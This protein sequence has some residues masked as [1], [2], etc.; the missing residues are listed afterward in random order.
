MT[1]VE[2]VTLEASNNGGAFATFDTSGI[3]S[4]ERITLSADSDDAAYS[5][6]NL[7]DGAEVRFLAEATSTAVTVDTAGTSVTLMAAGDTATT[8]TISDAVTVNVK[9]NTAATNDFAALVLDDDV[10]T[11]LTLTGSTTDGADLLTGN[12]TGSNLL[13]SITA[14]TDTTTTATTMQR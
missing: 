1:N 2:R 14:T 12:I 9:A 7:V 8:P 4:L 6:T 5:I 10:T 13:S 3:A 11:T